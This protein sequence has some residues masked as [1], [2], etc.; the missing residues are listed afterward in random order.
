MTWTAE[1]LAAMPDNGTAE[2]DVFMAERYE[3]ARVRAESE[4][5]AYAVRVWTDAISQISDTVCSRRP[6]PR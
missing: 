5:D 4:G 3:R 2:W 6:L 1:E